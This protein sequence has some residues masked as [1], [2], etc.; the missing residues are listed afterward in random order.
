[1]SRLGI[2]SGVGTFIGVN[3]MPVFGKVLKLP[4]DCPGPCDQ[5]QD[6][7]CH[8]YEVQRRPQTSFILPV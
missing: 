2:M 7:S 5:H 3:E 4:G 1:M 8:S 6:G